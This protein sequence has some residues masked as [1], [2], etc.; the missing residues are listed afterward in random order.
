MKLSKVLLGSVL[1]LASFS[2]LASEET[3]VDLKANMKEMKLEFRQAAEAQ[4]IE[5]MQA[6]VKQLITLVENSKTG[7][8]APEKNDLYQEGFNKLTIALD[9]VNGELAQGNLEAAKQALVEVDELRK[10][11][12][13]KKKTSI[14]GKLFS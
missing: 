4:D 10:E 12:H 3:K 7:E 2:G 5:S 1:V 14:W 9:K 11:Y 6:A 13:E 8:Y